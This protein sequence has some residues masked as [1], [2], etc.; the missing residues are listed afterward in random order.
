MPSTKLYH[1]QRKFCG[2][3]NSRSSK[4][5]TRGMQETPSPKMPTLVSHTC[6]YVM[7]TLLLYKVPRVLTGAYKYLQTEFAK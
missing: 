3:L 1:R 4:D 7:Y 6:N 2:L 5:L